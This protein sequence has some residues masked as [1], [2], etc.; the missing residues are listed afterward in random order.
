M[1]YLNDEKELVERN[2]TKQDILNSL[3][4]IKRGHLPDWNFTR[5]GKDSFPNEYYPLHVAMQAASKAIEA[6]DD[7]FF[8]DL[9]AEYVKY[10]KVPAPANVF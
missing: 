8:E 5:K 2:I 6:M 4:Y 10:D 9:D 1:K 3:A 7:K